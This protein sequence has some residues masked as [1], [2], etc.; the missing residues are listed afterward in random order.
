[1]KI[2]VTGHKGFIGQNLCKAVIEE[3]WELSTFDIVDNPT[4]RPKDLDF[5]DVNCVMH[6]GA[7]SS[8]TEKDIRK[9]MDQNLSWSIELYEEC[10][11]RGIHMQF[12]SSASVYGNNRS[13]RIFSEDNICY[14]SSYYAMSKYMFEQY[15]HKKMFG[16][17]ASV[18]QIFRYFNVY[19]PHEEHKGSQA[20]PYT[21]FAK[22]AKESG[23]IKVFKG[24]ENIYRDFVHVDTVV[25]AHI[26][27][28]KKIDEFSGGVYNVGSGNAR[29]F[30]DVAKDVALLHNAKIEEITFPE[31]LKEY[32][33]YYTQANISKLNQLLSVYG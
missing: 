27:G 2:L 13:Q 17:N 30:L 3:G 6:L 19:G 29:S 28:L 5:T 31:H 24:S 33:Q 18:L 22:Q 20:S 16:N 1:M 7:I 11:E 23:T 12:A 32:Y 4:F 14:P 9:I 10:R 8:T 21:Q 15:A 25:K 26:Q